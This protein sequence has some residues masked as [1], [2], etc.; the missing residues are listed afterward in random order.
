MTKSG[1]APVAVG[2]GVP[3]A[4][5]VV[6]GTGSI[7]DGNGVA[8]GTTIGVVTAVIVGSAGVAVTVGS[9]GV[10]V[11]SG[12]AVSNAAVALATGVA[13]DGA[14]VSVAVDAGVALAAA[15]AVAA[16][17]D[18]VTVGTGATGVVV[19]TGAAGVVVALGAAGVPP[20]TD[21]VTVA[22]GTP[23]VA[24]APGADAVGV[25]VAPASHD[26]QQ[27]LTT[28]PP[29]AMQTSSES[30]G[31]QRPDGPSPG[32]S[33]RTVRSRLPQSERMKQP[34]TAFRHPFGIRPSRTP[35][36]TTRATHAR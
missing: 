24:G 6:D 28:S 34:F 9:P 27:L 20:P 4:L 13:V 8:L 3:A 5:G 26:E 14:S 19:A 17:V 18:A 7:T 10:V 21:A 1:L 23:G 33:Q 32:R 31:R 16:G 29:R 22:A 36:F 25:G 35:R 11:A 12:V 2:T 30:S 15:V